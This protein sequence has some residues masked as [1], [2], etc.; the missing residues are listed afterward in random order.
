MT[1]RVTWDWDDDDPEGQ[2]YLAVYV[3]QR[4]QVL[5]AQLDGPTPPS[6]PDLRNR[7]ERQL[8]WWRNQL[9]A[10]TI[11]DHWTSGDGDRRLF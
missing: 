3:R 6:D 2:D 1:A 4:I 10:A 5:E 11:D 7:L 9:E 8:A